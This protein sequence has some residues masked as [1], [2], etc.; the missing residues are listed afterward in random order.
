VFFTPGR[1]DMERIKID[2]KIG[3]RRQ[4]HGKLRKLFWIYNLSLIL[5]DYLRR[6]EIKLY[7]LKGGGGDCFHRE[8]HG[9]TFLLVS[10]DIK[11]SRFRK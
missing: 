2:E 9:V 3:H 7:I 4:E 6:L 8:G 1:T 5:L 10:L 11:V